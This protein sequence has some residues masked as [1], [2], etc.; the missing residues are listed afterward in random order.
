MFV[1]INCKKA[2]ENPDEFAFLYESEKQGICKECL[3][4]K[5]TPQQIFTS[6]TD[7]IDSIVIRKKD[8]QVYVYKIENNNVKMIGE[9]YKA[10]IIIKG[11]T[12][13]PLILGSKVEEEIK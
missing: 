1:C 8:G 12:Y 10:R 3:Q 13:S 5:I 6:L 2:Y 9:Y 7:N 11:V 4:N